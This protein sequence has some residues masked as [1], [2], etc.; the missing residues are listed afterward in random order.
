MCFRLSGI[1]DYLWLAFC[2]A[3]AS[4]ALLYAM[5]IQFGGARARGD[6]KILYDPPTPIDQWVTVIF[7]A[8]W[9]LWA[10]KIIAYQWRGRRDTEVS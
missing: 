10:I 2:V 4:V 6:I 3:F 1:L 9:V 8:W 7:V 5:A